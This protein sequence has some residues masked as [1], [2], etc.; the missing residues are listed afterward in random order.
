MHTRIAG[1][2]GSIARAQGGAHTVRVNKRSVIEQ[3]IGTGLRP[4]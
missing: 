1:I 3:M 4:C 2:A